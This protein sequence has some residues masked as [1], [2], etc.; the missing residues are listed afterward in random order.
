[1]QVFC[2]IGSPLYPPKTPELAP[3]LAPGRGFV[4]TRNT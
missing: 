2:G 4:R 1:M 3:E